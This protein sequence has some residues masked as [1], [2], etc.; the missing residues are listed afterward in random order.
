MKNYFSSMVAVLLLFFGMTLNA[1]TYL[2]TA[3]AIKAVNSVI[4][5]NSDKTASI[6]SQNY[7]G[8]GTAVNAVAA[9]ANLDRATKVKRLKIQYGKD[10]LT[11]LNVGLPVSGALRKAA[12]THEIP[13]KVRG[14]LDI[15]QE[16]D[17]FYKNLLTR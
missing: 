17:L 5:Q 14:E 11:G 16:V 8:Q 12:L 9:E 15:F 1:Q 2:P 10:L 6:N 7:S 13:A 4:I 3:D